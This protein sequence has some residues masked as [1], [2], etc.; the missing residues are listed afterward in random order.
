M[1]AVSDPVGS[2]LVASLAR[3]GAF[4]EQWVRTCG[5]KNLLPQPSLNFSGRGWI[6][7]IF[8]GQIASFADIKYLEPFDAT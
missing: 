1:V 5:S 2:G 7:D 6:D 4:R 8:R 3:P